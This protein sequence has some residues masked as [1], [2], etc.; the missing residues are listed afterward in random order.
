MEILNQYTPRLTLT[1]IAKFH[2]ILSSHIDHTQVL[3][4][5]SSL[6][7]YRIRFCVRFL[8]FRSTS[9]LGRIPSSHPP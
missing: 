4:I 7:A 6:E 9:I 3:K 5:I 8:F 1:L 2:L